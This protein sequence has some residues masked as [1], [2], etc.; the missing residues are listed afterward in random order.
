MLMVVKDGFEAVGVHG[1]VGGV[2]GYLNGDR[3]IFVIVESLM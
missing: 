1:G 3:Q 2:D